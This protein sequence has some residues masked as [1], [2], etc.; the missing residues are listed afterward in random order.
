MSSINAKELYKDY[1]DR[2]GIRYRMT[3]E[4]I[5]WFDYMAGVYIED[6]GHLLPKNK[7][8]SK[9]IDFIKSIFPS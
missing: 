2:N 5:E 4:V 8:Y 9:M 3:V 7:D 1:C 6:Y